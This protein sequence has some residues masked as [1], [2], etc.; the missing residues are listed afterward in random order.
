MPNKPFTRGL[1]K[2]DLQYLA[3]NM[4]KEDADE[5]KASSGLQPL[6]ALQASILFSS[7]VWIGDEGDG[8]PFVI[9]GVN[10]QGVIWMLGTESIAKYA[11]PFLRNS[12]SLLKEAHKH[13]PILFNKSDCRNEVHHKWLRWMGFKFI[14]KSN[15]GVEQR[16]FYEFVRIETHV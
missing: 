10:K 11:I 8:T 3:E 7:Q 15:H 9:W 12:K 13:S 5:V 14:N 4:R 6:P 2:G 16:P 1:A